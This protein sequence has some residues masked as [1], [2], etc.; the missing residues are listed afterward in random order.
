MKSSSIPLCQ[1]APPRHRGLLLKNQTLLR[2]CCIKE[3]EEVAEGR[4]LQN[5]TRVIM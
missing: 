2:L 3:K 1:R 5:E 4:N